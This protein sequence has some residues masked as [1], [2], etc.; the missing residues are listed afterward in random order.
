MSMYKLTDDDPFLCSDCRTLGYCKR[1]IESASERVDFLVTDKEISHWVPVNARKV[2][3]SSHF[4]KNLQRAH[5]SFHQGEFE[6]ASYLYRDL[7]STRS[8]SREVL[9]GL[10]AS[11]FFQSQFDEAAAIADKL[12]VFE[13]DFAYKF[14]TTCERRS[15][16]MKH[17]GVTDEKSESENTE[18]G[19]RKS[20]HETN[21][22]I[23][24]LVD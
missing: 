12:T 21:P 5:D 13:L 22:G 18:M 8:E 7:L 23:L 4:Y 16:V 10:A 2:N 15:E 3:G 6:T 11:L 20:V 19:E 14:A 9:I 1:R 17:V 24:C